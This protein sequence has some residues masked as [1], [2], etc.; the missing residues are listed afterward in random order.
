MKGSENGRTRKIHAAINPHLPK[1]LVSPMTLTSIHHLID[2]K[3]DRY[4]RLQRL[5]QQPAKK[6]KSHS[7]GDTLTL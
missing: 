4:L 1:I 3:A 2:C 5:Q 6:P 7:Q